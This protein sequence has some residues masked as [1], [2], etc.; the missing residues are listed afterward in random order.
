MN[1]IFAAAVVVTL[2]SAIGPRYMNPYKGKSIG[3]PASWGGKARGKLVGQ[4]D[5]QCVDTRRVA[6][7]GKINK[8]GAEFE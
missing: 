8:N 1:W 4:N 2:S 6:D 7:S 5:A 3:L